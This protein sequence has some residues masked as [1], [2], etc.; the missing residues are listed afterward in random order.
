M[1]YGCCFLLS[2]SLTLLSLVSILLSLSAPSHLSLPLPLSLS[3]S[4]PLSHSHYTHTQI[5]D[6]IKHTFRTT[7]WKV[8]W[9]IDLSHW[10]RFH[11]WKK[12][13]GSTPDDAM[14]ALTSRNATIATRLEQSRYLFMRW[15]ELY[16]MNVTDD[17]GLTI[18]GFY[19]ICMDKYTGRVVGYYCD[20]NSTPFQ[21]L[22]LRP[23]SPEN[24]KGNTFQSSVTQ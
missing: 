13:F 3:P 5:I 6:G 15:K 7:K 16:F 20:P 22:S 1:Y 17:C 9:D 12:M 14:S 11:P 24:S 23:C 4:L 19:Y 21:K 18:A 2:I 10:C 8:P